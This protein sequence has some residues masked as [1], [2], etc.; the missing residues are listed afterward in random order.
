MPQ[1]DHQTRP[2]RQYRKWRKVGRRRARRQQAAIA[3][4][5]IPLV[6][7]TEKPENAEHA[8]Q[9]KIW[10]AKERAYDQ[11]VKHKK[12]LEAAKM[13]AIAK[14][15]SAETFGQAQAALDGQ[16]R[17][18]E[19]ASGEM[20]PLYASTGACRYGAVCP[21]VHAIPTS[22]TR[23]LML[24]NMY[25]GL[26]YKFS[27]EDLEDTLERDEQDIAEHLATWTRT[28]LDKLRQYGDVERFIVCKNRAP[29]LQGSVY[30]QY[31]N[32]PESVNARDAM[33]GIWY[34]HKTTLCEFIPDLDWSKAICEDKRAALG[35]SGAMAV[36]VG[37]LKSVCDQFK[38]QNASPA[39]QTLDD[40]EQTL[41]AIGNLCFDHDDNRRRLLDAD[42]V[43]PIVDVARNRESRIARAACGSLLNASMSC[44]EAQNS[45][46][47]C[48]GIKVLLEV[49]QPEIQHIVVNCLSNVMDTESGSQNVASNELY[50]PM[51]RK[52]LAYGEADSEDLVDEA[53]E[54]SALMVLLVQEC[55]A[56][57][58]IRNQILTGTL[59]NEIMQTAEENP[60][61]RLIDVE[62]G[63]SAKDIAQNI[64]KI[65][66]CVLEDQ[67]I[68]DLQ[69]ER[70]Y[71]VETI[72]RWLQD[73][74]FAGRTDLPICAAVTLGNISRN[75]RASSR[76]VYEHEIHRLAIN[77]L[78]GTE[79][80]GLQHALLGLLRN[81]SLAESNKPLLAQEHA[82]KVAIPYLQSRKD[83]LQPI[84][85]SAIGLIKNCCRRNIISARDFLTADD[86][87]MD[88]LTLL[89]E[90]ANRT[91]E[92][93]LKVEGYRTVSIVIKTVWENDPVETLPLRQR[94]MEE[95]VVRAMMQL[96]IVM[97][98][99]LPQNEGILAL[100]LLLVENDREGA[101]S[102]NEIREWLRV[103][104][105]LTEKLEAT[106]KDDKSP[107]E[108]RSNAR[109]LLQLYT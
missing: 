31:R 77:K 94:L 43:R 42:G 22:P 35:E 58:E 86:D 73:E 97:D 71:L 16:K 109:Q 88:G 38:D 5:A 104:A 36:L 20:C 49:E 74:S 103:N 105:Q 6:T 100:S 92:K 11:I 2:R 13:A 63:E 27:D 12:A 30:V 59:L 44:D 15:P 75:D 53:Q 65:I 18:D 46:V 34:D 72:F 78:E 80:I 57:L 81:L 54:L 108:V 29:H 45:L 23:T 9:R 41:R 61:R 39:M 85:A 7:T 4:Q 8:K 47:E 17:T 90:L 79:D 24:P 56:K 106:V 40:V 70:S 84:Q 48:D 33:H 107:K 50:R 98:H 87:G 82:V 52:F 28:L 3:R 91:E 68:E 21:R 14:E 25:S 69:R 95:R 76:L 66:G 101:F 26:P 67:D 99:P 19:K 83:M 64:I 102:P 96:V 37:F 62:G 10:E 60:W 93:A 1:V 51:W 55:G 32:T 89:I